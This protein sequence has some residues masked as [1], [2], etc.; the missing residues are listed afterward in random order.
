MTFRKKILISAF[1]AIFV[2]AFSLTAFASTVR[3]GVLSKLNTDESDFT[4]F[5]HAEGLCKGLNNHGGDD[6]IVFYD[7]ILSMLLRE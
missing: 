6:I 2:L 5:I 4:D 7:S 1:I 3:V